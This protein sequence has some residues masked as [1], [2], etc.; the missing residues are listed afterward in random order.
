MPL[1]GLGSNGGDK[2][3]VSVGSNSGDKGCVSVGIWNFIFS[4]TCKYEITNCD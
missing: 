2:G 1:W 3:C 4:Y